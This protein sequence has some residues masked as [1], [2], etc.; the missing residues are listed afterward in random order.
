M[1][2]QKLDSESAYFDNALLLP[3]VLKLICLHQIYEKIINISWDTAVG[4]VEYLP[5]FAVEIMT[6]GIENAN[7][8]CYF[9]F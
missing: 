6:N 4:T 9:V 5:N 7:C 3:S 2:M 1:K 8:Q